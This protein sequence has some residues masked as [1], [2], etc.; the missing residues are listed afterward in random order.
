MSG[1]YSPQQVE[2][3]VLD[4]LGLVVSIAKSLRPTNYTELEE[5]IQV[6]TIGLWKAIEKH[7]PTRAKL[8]T[9]AW[10]SIRWEII[11]YIEKT[12]KYDDFINADDTV[13]ILSKQH[14]QHARA[15]ERYPNRFQEW[16]PG[17]L[18]KSERI[19]VEM[20]NQGYTFQE[21][22][23]ALGGYTRGWANKLF[24]SA[25]EKIRDANKETYIDGE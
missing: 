3:L 15:I 23:H 14:R 8:S 21:I 6:G 2:Q 13:Y 20:R 19:V 16:L 17:D 7:D 1:V 4:N 25:I 24:K 11:R 9:L 12:K 18:S 22:G 10:N 5:Y